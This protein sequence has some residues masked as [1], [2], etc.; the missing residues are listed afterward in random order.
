MAKS[1]KLTDALARLAAAEERFLASEFLAPVVS[2]GP[3]QV[4]IAGVICS[5]RIQPADFAGWGVFRPVS[6]GEAKLVRQAKLGERQRHLEL[7]PLVRLI[8]LGRHEQQWLAVPAHRGDS[9]FRI[10]GRSRFS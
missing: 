3:V 7:F 6:H 1:R 2:G 4:R 5:L 8:L 10:E 9:R